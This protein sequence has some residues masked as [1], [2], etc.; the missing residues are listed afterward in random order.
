MSLWHTE[1]SKLAGQHR[2]GW[3][4]V[5]EDPHQEARGSL[6]VALIKT[7]EQPWSG[8]W[9]VGRGRV[10]F[11]NELDLGGVTRKSCTMERSEDNTLGLGTVWMAR[12][13]TDDS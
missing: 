5:R 12:G 6:E 8:E 4:K 2:H 1:E 13:I 11:W 7:T 10:S 3:N 9:E